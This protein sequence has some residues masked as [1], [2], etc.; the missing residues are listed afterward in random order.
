MCRCRRAPPATPRPSRTIR[1]SS[2]SIPRST[3]WPI[4]PSWRRAPPIRRGQLAGLNTRFQ[5]GL[6]QVEQYLSSTSFNNFTLQAAKPSASRS[7]RPRPCR[8]GEF[9]LCDPAAGHQ[10]QY[11]QSAARAFRLQQLHYLGEEGRRHDRCA[12]RPSP[13][14]GSADPGQYRQLHQF[15]ALGG[16][17]FDPLPEDPKGRHRHLGHRATYGLQITPG[18]MKR[19]HFPP[20]RRPRSTWWAIPVWPPRPTPPRRQIRHHH[21]HHPRRPERPPDQVVGP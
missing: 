20:R 17:L 11:R 10:R 9:H 6:A 19:F 21:D 8:F 13:G 16:R 4:S 1:S 5:T 12:D 3:P 15:A 18:A 7:P 2:R 14:A